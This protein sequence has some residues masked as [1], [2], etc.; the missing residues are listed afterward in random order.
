VKKIFLLIFLCLLLIPLPSAGEDFYEKQ[1]DR[2]LKNSVAYS[3]ILIERSKAEPARAKYYLREA[4]RYSPDLP[5]VYFELSKRS[6]SPSLEGMVESFNFM[7]DGIVAYQRNFWWSFTLSGSLFLSFFLSF[8]LS[9][10]IIILIRLPQDV[11]LLSH[12]ALETKEKFLLLLLLLSAFL[13]PLF[14][15]GAFLLLLGIY[16]KKGDKA[17]IYLFLL[18][19]LL[20][21]FIFRAASMFLNASASN[22]LKAVV[23]V[24]ESKDNTYALSVLKGNDDRIALFSYALALKREG[25]YDEAIATYNKLIDPKPDPKVYNN[26]ANCYAGKNDFER[27]KDF[28]ERSIGLKPLTS[29]YYNLSQV[30]RKNL[31]FVK[32]EE[33]FLFAQ[34]LNPAA[35]SSFQ[36]IFSRNPNRFVIDEVLPH[37]APW[38]YTVEK[39]TNVS[40]LGLSTLPPAP[41]PF[42]AFLFGIIFYI[43]N[44]RIKTRAYRCKKCGTILCQKCEKRLL[45]GH[46]CARCYSSL[47]K[48][49]ELGARE[50]I[51][52]LQ[53]VYRYQTKRRG[54]LKILTTVLPGS[55]QIYAGNILKGFLILWLILFFLFIPLVN[56]VFV[57]EVSSFSHIWLN[58]ISLSL[59]ATF[60]FISNIATR[61]RLAKGWL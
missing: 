24:N 13:G 37:A 58:V 14:L 55:A 32:G 9:I 54:L 49:D 18:F 22:V 7:L 11:S 4:L 45:W 33:Y 12:D 26:L 16:F 38:E 3:Y 6:L 40:T 20:S 23:Q 57:V 61:R 46:M 27:A 60:Y 5:A 56:S 43:L 8:L 10:F 2:G 48:L 51:A 47:V 29:A 42:G 19:I 39:M 31:D 41:L 35:V 17:I 52:R 53:T 36:A 44:R 34:K 25:R 50:R 21:P 59:F 30:S 15:M 28:Y 1:L